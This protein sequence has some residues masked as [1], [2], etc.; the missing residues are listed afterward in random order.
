MDALLRY[1]SLHKKY[2]MEGTFET[3]LMLLDLTWG[4]LIFVD[5]SG[6]NI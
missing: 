3:D 6:G 4:E 2:K 1:L 5:K